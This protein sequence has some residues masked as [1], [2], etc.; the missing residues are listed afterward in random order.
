MALQRLNGY[1]TYQLNLIRLL[2]YGLKTSLYNLLRSLQWLTKPSGELVRRLVEFG[3]ICKPVSSGMESHLAG[4]FSNLRYAA[5]AVVSYP[6][7]IHTREDTANVEIIIIIG[8]TFN[9]AI[10]LVMIEH[11]NSTC[12]H[13]AE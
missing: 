8:D 10:I 13:A 3:K 6:D 11:E 4:F 2:N 9:L 5:V 12:L 7:S 1:I